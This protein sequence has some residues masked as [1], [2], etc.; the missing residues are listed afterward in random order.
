MAVKL[1]LAL[2]VLLLLAWGA[3]DL[4]WRIRLERSLDRIRAQGDPV[5][6][7]DI[8]FPPRPAGEDPSEWLAEFDDA[9]E[10]SSHWCLDDPKGFAEL[11]A[12]AR[13]GEFDP[14]IREALEILDGCPEKF[15]E[16][17][18]RSDHTVWGR[19][20][21]RLG[22][23][24]R[25]EDLTP[26]SRAALQALSIQ[27]TPVRERAADACRYAPSDEAR[28][29]RTVANPVEA[30]TPSPVF[31]RVDEAIKV[32]IDHAPAAALRARPESAI[33]SLRLAFCCARLGDSMLGHAGHTARCDLA[34]RA[35]AGLQRTLPLLPKDLD[36]TVIDSRLDAID[37][38]AQLVRA[39]KEDRAIINAFYAE[40]RE[41]FDQVGYESLRK[42][43]PAALPEFLFVRRDQA[44][45]LSYFE[46]AFTDIQKPYWTYRASRPSLNDF[47]ESFPS[48][49]PVASMITPSFFATIDHTVLLETR[50]ALARGALI[51][52]RYGS[53]A[54][55]QY[56][57]RTIDPFSGEPMHFRGEPDGVIALWSVGMNLVDDDAPRSD[58]VDPEAPED[59]DVVWRI[60][61]H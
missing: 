2:F 14:D 44:I 47:V 25:P 29:L 24:V 35:L 37:P 13:S 23:A 7:A 49:A 61:L 59:P 31:H 38:H 32:L 60:R 54:A 36:L 20:Y 46:K 8:V 22:D 58:Q 15:W 4:T 28:R 18:D 34:F 51:A 50:L 56:A 27:Y 1:A 57:A 6:P 12:R 5:L 39:F 9:D 11:L 33:E 41:A 55:R 53:E 16:E 3:F 30:L 43:S 19:L 40:F 17:V 52:Y 48:C 10:V 45:C 21:G 42:R 26:C